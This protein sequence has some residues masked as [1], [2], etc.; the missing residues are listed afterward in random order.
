MPS[1]LVAMTTFKGTLSNSQASSIVAKA[2]QSIGY[3]TYELPVGDGGAGTIHAIHSALGGEFHSFQVTSPLGAIV[4]ANVLCL[5][6]SSQPIKVYIESSDTCGYKLVP[7]VKRDAMKAT[8]AGL[9]QLI[10][11][12]RLKW[13]NSLKELVIGLG[14]SAVSDA[15]I[16]MLAALGFR[17]LD[18]NSIP[19]QATTANLQRVK[20]IDASSA[21]SLPAL[22]VLCDVRNS[23]CGPNGSA[24]VFSPQ[25][26]ASPEEV[27]NIEQGMNSFAQVLG[28]VFG[29]NPAAIPHTGS[30]GGISAALYSS[31]NAALVS[32]AKFLF[33]WICFDSILQQY[34]IL[35]TGEGRTDHQTLS[36]K[37]PLECLERA[38][39]LRKPVYLVSGSLGEGYESI[40]KFSCVRKVLGSGLEP[41]AHEALYRAT[42]RLFD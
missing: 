33:D 40:Q 22:T 3:Q 27:E 24:R 36:G 28:S 30:A 23:L 34:D 41:S 8:S 38:E 31:Y 9:G 25:K 35:V 17:F 5:P 18:E 42:R 16:G 20:K 26:G 32:G 14:D 2:L 29:R 1:A 21:A 37:A 39:R 15:G 7:E 11:E 12:C 13:K 4:S 10:A 6:N 19:L